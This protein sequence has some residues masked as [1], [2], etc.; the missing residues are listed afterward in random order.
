MKLLSFEQGEFLVKLA[1]KIIEAHVKN[2][3]IK[4]PKIEDWML[5]KRGV[6]T[7]IETYPKLDL[8]GCIGIPYPI[9]SIIDALFISAKEACSD[10]RF[11]PLSMNE[12]EKI[13]IEVSVLS[14]PEEIKVRSGEEYIEKIEKYKDGII[15]KYGSASA[16]FLPQVWEKID[17]KEEFLSHL[18]IKAGIP[19]NIWKS[20]KAKLFKFHA[21]VF[22]EDSPNGRIVEV[23]PK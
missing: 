9:Y 7:T 8:R 1:R 15:I 2:K 12:L 16:L 14:I 6:F 18:C 22:K 23:K 11:E 4:R 21:Q 17:S 10:P 5:E 20:N 13:V 19:P 3:D